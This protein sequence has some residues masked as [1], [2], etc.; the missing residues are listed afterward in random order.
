[1]VT[2]KRQRILKSWGALLI[3]CEGEE[4]G[5]FR[6]VEQNL[7]RLK[8]PAV[9]WK[10]E[11]VSTGLWQG[12]VS[13]RR[14]DYILLGHESLKD[15]VLCVGARDYG[16]SLNVCWYLTVPAISMLLAALLRIP[17][18]GVFL[19]RIVRFFGFTKDLDIFEEQ[20]LS[21]YVSAVQY[22]VRK[23]VEDL[24]KKQD[25]EL[26]IDWNATAHLEAA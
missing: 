13:G 5:F 23:A 20:D 14:R 4:E 19:S 11:S 17:F 10:R 22:A 26:A 8:P 15:Y 12:M 6:M 24:L 9:S 3:G 2:L 18:V 16:A 7:E 1:M 25:I 21:A